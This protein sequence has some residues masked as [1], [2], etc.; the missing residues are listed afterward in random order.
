MICDFCGHQYEKT[1]PR[2]YSESHQLIKLKKKFK[3]VQCPTCNRHLVAGKWTNSSL[4]EALKALLDKNLALDRLASQIKLRTEFSESGK[5]VF[6]T[7]DANGTIEGF[8]WEQTLYRPIDIELKNCKVCS[9]KAGHYY[10]ATLQIRASGRSPGDEELQKAKEVVLSIASTRQ[11]TILREKK[12]KGGIDYEIAPIR[13]ARL[14]ARHLKKIGAVLSENTHHLS[15]NRQTGKAIFRW[16]ILARLPDYNLGDFVEMGGR[17]FQVTKVGANTRV[18]RFDGKP[19]PLKDY[20]LIAREDD[21]KNGQV[22]S[23]HKKAKAIQLMDEDFNTFDLPLP[24]VPVH[25]GP[26]KYLIFNRAINP[27][28]FTNKKHS[29]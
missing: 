9:Q 6:V 15:Q 17:L 18:R 3:I 5:T 16:A 27:I 1:C 21:A 23:I 25:R 22:I 28:W 20:K 11:N 13:T 24:E 26:V 12:V 10:E 8:F 29:S 19:A 2:C 14:M 4:A 7:V